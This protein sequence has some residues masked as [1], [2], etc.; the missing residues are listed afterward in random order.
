MERAFR[1]DA[2]RAARGRLDFRAGTPD[3]HLFPFT[4][5]RRLVAREL[6]PVAATGRRTAIPRPSGL[7]AAIARHIGVSRAVRADADDVIVT[8]GA[9]QA[10]DLIGRVLIEPGLRGSGGTRVPARRAL[11]QSLGAR[12]VGVPV[13]DEGL[14]VALIPERRGWST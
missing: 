10:L 13:D 7:R 8:Q 6:R 5:W 9:Q 2:G 4:T 12:V 11:F 3:P 14:V 1:S